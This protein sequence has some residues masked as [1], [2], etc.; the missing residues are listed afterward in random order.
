MCIR[1]SNW[2]GNVAEYYE[3]TDKLE[4]NDYELV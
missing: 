1:D 2:S 3:L 4:L